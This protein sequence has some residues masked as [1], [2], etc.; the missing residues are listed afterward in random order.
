[1]KIDKQGIHGSEFELMIV[2]ILIIM[3]S[4]IIGTLAGHF[5]ADLILRK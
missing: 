5:V 4:S 2:M 1:M 3:V